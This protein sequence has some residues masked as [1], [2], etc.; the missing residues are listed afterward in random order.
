MV[1]PIIIISP[2]RSGSSMVAGLFKEHGAW[3]GKTKPGDKDNPNGFFENTAIKNAMLRRFGRDWLGQPPEAQDEWMEQVFRIMSEEGYIGGPWLFKTG[4]LYYQVWEP[5][6]PLFVK[7][8][9]LRTDILK[10][11]DRCGYLSEYEPSGRSAIVERQ[12]GIM[13]MLPGPDIIADQLVQGNHKRLAEALEAA[14]LEYDRSL[15]N[16][17][18]D[19]GAWHA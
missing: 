16:E 12:H 2:G 5:F 17:F 11:Y 18:V 19:R 10:S 7:V 3:T 14:G 13:E 9:R 6:A 4:A 1:K 8:W 15:V